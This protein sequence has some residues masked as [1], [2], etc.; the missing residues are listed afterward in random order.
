M[1]ARLGMADPIQRLRLMT[2]AG[3]A[4]YSVAGENYW[5]DEDLQS[6]LD[7]VRR[8][9]VMFLMTAVPDY[10]ADGSQEYR[11][12]NLP[13]SFQMVEG[14]DGGTDFFNVQ[15]SAGTIIS[16]DDFTFYPDALEIYFTNDQGGTAYY[17]TG[18]T[19]DMNEAAAQVW[20][21]KAAH[22]VTAINFSADGH[23]F[24][25]GVLQ[26][27]CKDQAA[28]FRGEQGIQQSQFVRVDVNPGPADKDRF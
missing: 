17:W 9:R 3:T 19:Y 22:Y 20:D 7:R 8:R 16:T 28:L 13:R 4:D 14:T 27:H 2:E 23:K 10:S 5:D 21:R 12:Y 11:R 6:V 18:F 26:A 24:D 25:R 15:T 1:A